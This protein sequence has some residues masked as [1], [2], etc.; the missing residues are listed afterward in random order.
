MIVPILFFVVLFGAAF[1][2]ALPYAVCAVYLGASTLT[3][4]VYAFDKAAARAGQPRTRE[5][6]LHLCSLGCGWPGALLAQKTLRH[7]SVKQPF[8]RICIAT[9]ACNC[10]ALLLF[11]FPQLSLRALALWNG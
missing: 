6:T 3:F 2:D 5:S 11:V 9:V 10:G 1:A 8:R 4:T 7:K